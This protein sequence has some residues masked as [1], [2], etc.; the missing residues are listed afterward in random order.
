MSQQGIYGGTVDHTK[1]RAWNV[2]EYRKKAEARERGE[3]VDSKP[4]KRSSAIPVQRG[5]LKEREELINLDEKVGKFTSVN[6]GAPSS[7]LGAFHCAVCDCTLKDSMTYLDHLNGKN[8]QRML[9]MSLR[10]ERSSL[11]DVR[12]RLNKH[13]R[14]RDDVKHYDLDE[15]VKKAQED[16]EEEKRKKKQQ[17]KEK[18][19]DEKKKDD[20]DAPEF[21]APVEG[22][23]DMAAL[24]LPTGFNSSNPNKK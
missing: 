22:E 21:V 15:R 12:D 13:K 11:Q 8:H 1:R 5:P 16:E 9:G 7:E 6:A 19:E 2:D 23:L 14:K 20:E 10:V 3:D 18:K 17:K 24:G 4:N